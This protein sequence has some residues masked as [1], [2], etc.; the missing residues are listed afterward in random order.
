VKAHYAFPSS[1]QGYAAEIEGYFLFLVE[2]A[3][4][5]H[6]ERVMYVLV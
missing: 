4:G 5:E 3:Y 6:P 1:F 2:A